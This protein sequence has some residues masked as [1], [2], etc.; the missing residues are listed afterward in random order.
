MNK[1]EREMKETRDRERKHNI[2]IEGDGEADW[3][4]GVLVEWN[5]EITLKQSAKTELISLQ[6]NVI[7]SSNNNKTIS[8]LCKTALPSI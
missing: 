5:Q 1:R 8:I 2:E 6:S 4:E 3:R 7:L